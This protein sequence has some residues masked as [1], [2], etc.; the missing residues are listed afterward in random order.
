MTDMQIGLKTAQRLLTEQHIGQVLHNV[1]KSTDRFGSYILSFNIAVKTFIHQ[2]VYDP[3]RR[4]VIH[5]SPIPPTQKEVL[6]ALFSQARPRSRE[7]ERERQDREE[8]ER[9]MDISRIGEGVNWEFLGPHIPDEVNS[10]NN[11]NKQ[12]IYTF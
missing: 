1:T 7:T 11:P 6:A 5:L 4:K 12:I 10:P 2:R 9:E 3:I 8:K